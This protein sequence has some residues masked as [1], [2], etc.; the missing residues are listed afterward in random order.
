MGRDA[1][2]TK[3]QLIFVIA[4]LVFGLVGCAGIEKRQ[5]QD[6]SLPTAELPNYI[7]GEYYMYDYAQMM[8]VVGREA[9]MLK[10]DNGGSTNILAHRN[11]LLPW[12][13]WKDGQSTYVT[14]L[15]EKNLGIWPLSPDKT[16]TFQ[17]IQ[18]IFPLDGGQERE[19]VR[20]WTC[21]VEKPERI[22]VPAG[23]FDTHV[24][25]CK[26]YSG[27]GGAWRGSEKYYYAPS[28]GHYVMV[29]RSYSSRPSSVH[30][31]TDYGF[32]SRLLSEKEQVDL[33]SKLNAVLN[34]QKEGVVEVWKSRDGSVGAMLSATSMF[35]KNERQ[36]RKYVSTYNASGKIRSHEK[37]M[38][39]E[40]KGPWNSALEVR[41]KI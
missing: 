1:M 13:E 37:V 38:C 22:E 4:S 25:F 19:V 32:N 14:T 24:I 20:N 31:L 23:V 40:A 10:W 8:T 6:L 18:R 11:F 15:S 5:K 30:Q 16:F 21:S 7:V 9:D 35:I 33:R 39:R 27:S 28:I 34:N 17:S 3:L 2:K 41:K 36:C 12:Q 26:R 29:E